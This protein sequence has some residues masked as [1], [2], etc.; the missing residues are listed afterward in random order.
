MPLIVDGG[1]CIPFPP[2]RGEAIVPTGS[3][4]SD[5]SEPLDS[6]N[7]SIPVIKSKSTRNKRV[8]SQAAQESQCVAVGACLLTP[9]FNSISSF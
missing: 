6:L 2:R 8:K 1:S 4:A 3:L 9:F 7:Y 5:L